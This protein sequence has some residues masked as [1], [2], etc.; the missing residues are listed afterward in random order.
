MQTLSKRSYLVT[1]GNI[2][3]LSC[4]NQ[5]DQKKKPSYFNLHSFIYNVDMLYIYILNILFLNE[6]YLVIS[7]SYRVLKIKL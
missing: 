5:V 7:F 1:T 6:I 2:I 3:N 4:A